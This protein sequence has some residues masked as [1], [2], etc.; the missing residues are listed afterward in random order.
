V[1]VRLDQNMAKVSIE[2]LMP[3]SLQLVSKQADVGPAI[4]LWSLLLWHTVSAYVHTTYMPCR[5]AS[6]WTA[7]TGMRI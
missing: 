6:M 4:K 7:V 3:L 1:T 5:S 2:L